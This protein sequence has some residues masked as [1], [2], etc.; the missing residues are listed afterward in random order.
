MAEHLAGDPVTRRRQPVRI[1]STVTDEWREYP[2]WPPSSAEVVR[3]LEPSG[4]LTTQQAPEGASSFTYDPAHPTPTV[5]G[6]INGRD[7]GVRDNRD[8]EARPDVLTFTTAALPNAWEIIGTPVVE[9]D[10]STSNPHA[11]VFVR[12]CDVDTKGRSHNFTETFL[13]LD[14]AEQGGRL[15]L[16]LHPCAHR[17]AAGHRLRLQVSGGSFPQYTRNEGTGA[18]PGTGTELRPCR[19][20]IHHGNSRLILPISA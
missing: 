16:R 20:T 8:L 13:R 10:H 15:R 19:H 11:D 1:Q 2:E 4:Q 5:A 12:L 18:P 9:L 17:L 3:Y 14:A 6:P 7:A